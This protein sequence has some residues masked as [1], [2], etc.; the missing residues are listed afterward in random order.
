MG[1]YVG[2]GVETEA[3]SAVMRARGA[4]MAILTAA[5]TLGAAIGRVVKGEGPG[6][7]RWWPVCT[8]V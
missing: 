1:G 7:W 8:V 6:T 2:A 4:D 3:S 5:E